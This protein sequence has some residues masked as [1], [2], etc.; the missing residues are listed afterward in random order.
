MTYRMTHISYELIPRFNISSMTG[1]LPIVYTVPVMSKLLPAATSSAF[2]AFAACT[3]QPVTTTIRGS[4]T[5]LAY[6]DVA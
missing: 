2:T 5:P 3:V 4:F 6:S 1:S